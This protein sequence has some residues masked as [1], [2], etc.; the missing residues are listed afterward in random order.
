MIECHA[1]ERDLG[2]SSVVD[3]LRKTVRSPHHE[4]DSFA[5]GCHQA[6]HIVGELH[7][8]ILLAPFVEEDY[9]V[10]RKHTVEE[11]IPLF[12][13]L[14]SFGGRLRH[15][16]IR[17]LEHREGEIMI[18]PLA[19]LA[20][21]AYDKIEMSLADSYQYNFHKNKDIT[22]PPKKGEKIKTPTK[23]IIKSE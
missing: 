19:I 15:L 13:F 9:E 23:I 7:R 1:R 14:L 4:E 6:F 10:G 22:P 12:L 17:E 8:T 21:T 3:S 20:D 18:K 2:V 11:N 5:A 16:D